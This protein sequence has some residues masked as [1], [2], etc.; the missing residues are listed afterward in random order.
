MTLKK[1]GHS[2]A[3]IFLLKANNKNTRKGVKYDQR[4]HKDTRTTPMANK[5]IIYQALGRAALKR[6]RRLF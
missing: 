6:R 2:P 4:H 5:K 1:Q 3:S